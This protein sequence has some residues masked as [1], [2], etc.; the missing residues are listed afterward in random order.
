KAD[1]AMGPK[2]TAVSGYVKRCGKPAWIGAL[3]RIDDTL[4]GRAGTCICL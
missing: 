4:A 1:G 2:V 3:S